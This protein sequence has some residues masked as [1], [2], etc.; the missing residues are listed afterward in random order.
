MPS[1]NRQSERNAAECARNRLS[2]KRQTATKLTKRNLPLYLPSAETKTALHAIP[3]NRVENMKDGF[4]FATPFVGALYMSPLWTN[5]SKAGSVPS[6]QG[7][8]SMEHQWFEGIQI[9]H[10]FLPPQKQAQ[11]FGRGLKSETRPAGLRAGFTD[12]RLQK[13]KRL[14]WGSSCQVGS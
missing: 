10:K 2:R 1:A 8:F 14:K 11:L 4:A 7:L 6:G 12:M 9:V 3:R 13:P 5:Q